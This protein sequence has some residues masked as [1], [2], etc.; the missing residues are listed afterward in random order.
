MRLGPK[1]AIWRHSSEPM[2]P[3]APVTITARPLIKLDTANSSSL[4]GSR[5]STSSGWMSRTR[6]MRVP[7]SRSS[8]AEGTVTTGSPVA[9]ASASTRLRCAW[10]AAGMARIRWETSARLARSVSRSSPPQTVTP[11]MRLPCLRGSSSSRPTTVQL[12]CWMP[13]ISNLA[14]AP[15]PSTRAR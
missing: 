5:P 8:S 15:A 12:R 6:S 9:A 4:T 11:A 1:R 14:A 2:E 10:V 13:A 3:P 7:P